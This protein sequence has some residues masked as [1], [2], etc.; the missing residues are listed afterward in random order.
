MKKDNIEDS[1]EDSENLDAQYEE[2]DASMQSEDLGAPIT[3]ENSR[4]AKMVDAVPNFEEQ[5]QDF[6][7]ASINIDV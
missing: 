1:A 4:V 5:I 2:P 3:N 6:H 7:N